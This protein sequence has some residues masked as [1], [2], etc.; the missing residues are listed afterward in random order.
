MYLPTVYDNSLMQIG[1]SGYPD[2]DSDWFDEDLDGQINMK[3]AYGWIWDN[4]PPMYPF[5]DTGFGEITYE[6]V[7]DYWY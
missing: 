6:A 1:C 2:T 4:C 7:N 3:L 5:I